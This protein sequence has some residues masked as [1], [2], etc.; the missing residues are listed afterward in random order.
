MQLLL[1]R[2][3]SNLP[4]VTFNQIIEA[5]PSSIPQ[6]FGL[7]ALPWLSLFWAVRRGVPLRPEV[8][9]AAVGLAAFCFAVALWQIVSQPV[10][11][12][13]GIILGLSCTALMA[14]SAVAGRFWLDWI[15]GSREKSVT[16]VVSTSKWVVFGDTTFFPLA[17]GASIIALLVVL[18]GPVQ[19]IAHIPDFD[20]A[21]ESY[22]RAL[23]DFR[24]NVPSTSMETMLTAYIEHGMPA[25][26]WD[27]GPEGYTLVRAAAGTLYPTERQSHIHGFVA[28]KAGSSA[29]LGRRTGSFRRR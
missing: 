29:S 12:P 7:A 3:V 23:V 2:S 4:A 26:M 6:L 22:E 19:H 13:S 28:K 16:A 17:L 5:A 18:I 21:L 20:L 24:P 15:T 10:R 27:F 11:L 1:R 25:Y 9:G 14:L 8:T